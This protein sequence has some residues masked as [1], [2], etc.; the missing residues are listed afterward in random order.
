[1]L[2][3]NVDGKFMVWYYPN[4]VYIDRNLVDSTRSSKDARYFV[5]LNILFSFC[6]ILFFLISFVYVVL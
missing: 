4:V 5:F 3:A 2:A 1:M 6:S